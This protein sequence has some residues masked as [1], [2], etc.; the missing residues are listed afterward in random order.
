MELDLEHTSS[1][2]SRCYAV[3]VKVDKTP[4]RRNNPTAML[5]LLPPSH[6]T[7]WSRRTNL[8]SFELS[9]DLGAR[10]RAGA[11]ARRRRQAQHAGV[12]PHRLRVILQICELALALTADGCGSTR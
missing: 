12:P 4:M 1:S 2:S 3:H 6:H 5:W 11:H 8:Q 9:G 10:P 7:G